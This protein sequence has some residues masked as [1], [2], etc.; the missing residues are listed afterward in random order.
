MYP[1]AVVS[2]PELNDKVMMRYVRKSADNAIDTI[3][4]AKADRVSAQ[5]PEITKELV[6]ENITLLD[7][8]LQFYLNTKETLTPLPKL[9]DGREVM[10]ILNINPSPILGKILN[11]LHEAQIS[12][13]ILTKDDAVRFI[14]SI[15]LD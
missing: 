11:E 13:D 9:L 4:I 2:A 15:P 3:I 14:K 1:T 6:E 10:S 7:K 8:L 5:G 12:G